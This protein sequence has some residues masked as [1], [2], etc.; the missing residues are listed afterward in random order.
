MDQIGW[1]LIVAGVGIA[2]FGYW[3]NRVAVARSEAAAG[4]WRQVPGTL[5]EASVG[6]DVVWGQDND[7]TVEY[8]P[9][10]RYGYQVDGR[11]F[12]GK[13]AFLS[14]TK[15]DHQAQSQVWQAKTKPGPVSVWHDP[16]DPASSVLEVDR[17]GKSGLFV[18]GVFAVILIGVGIS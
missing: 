18:A 14:R 10:V 15:F 5:H 13:R 16:A 2:A 3:R 9:V 1:V 7:Q 4:T 17:P 11:D 6:E 8:S 12:E